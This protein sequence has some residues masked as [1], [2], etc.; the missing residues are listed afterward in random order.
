[1]PLKGVVFAWPMRTDIDS[2]QMNIALE[3]PSSCRDQMQQ[4]ATSG[5]LPY[6]GMPSI[7]RPRIPRAPTRRPAP[8]TP[9]PDEL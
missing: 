3:G 6:L 5:D 1:M 9:D 7:Y 2:T 8:R 4:H